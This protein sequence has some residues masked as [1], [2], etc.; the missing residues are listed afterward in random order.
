M[1]QIL[2]FA[3]GTDIVVHIYPDCASDW[4]HLAA[5]MNLVW[6]CQSST[7]LSHTLSQAAN[8]DLFGLLL[9]IDVVCN[10]S[11][12]NVLDKSLAQQSQWRVLCNHASYLSGLQISSSIFCTDQLSE[13]WLL[14]DSTQC[15]DHIVYMHHGNGDMNEDSIDVIL[16][17]RGKFF[18][19]YYTVSR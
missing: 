15:P 3:R 5:K 2:F 14:T 9:L 8:M 6:L 12:A 17:K 10:G 19:L 1:P 13:T 11:D 7:V 4:V 16:L 18:A